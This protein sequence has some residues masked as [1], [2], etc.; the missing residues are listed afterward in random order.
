MGFEAC[1]SHLCKKTIKGCGHCAALKP[2]WTELGETEEASIGHIDCDEHRDTLCRDVHSFP[3]LKTFREGTASPYH[4]K[5]SLEALSLFVKK[6]T[7]PLVREATSRED[8]L[9]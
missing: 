9:V 8:V 5:R 1:L 4:G 6:Q 7:G 3:T 2:A